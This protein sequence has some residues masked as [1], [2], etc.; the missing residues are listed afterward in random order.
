MIV[1]RT[2]LRINFAAGGSDLPAYYHQA[3]GAVIGM[4]IATYVYVCVKPN[5]DGR[6]LAH[7]RATEDVE[8]ASDLRHTRMRACLAHFGIK[9]G[10]EIASLADVPGSTGLGSSGAFLVGL[11]TALAAYTNERIAPVEAARL[12]WQ[13]E[14]SIE[15][16]G[17]QD[18]YFAALGGAMLLGFHAD[19]SVAIDH[20]AVR[21]DLVDHLLLLATPL[22][23]DAGAILAEQ[24][25]TFASTAPIV[26]QIVEMAYQFVP[27]LERGRYQDAGA[28]LD[29][30][31]Q[32]K[33]ML[34]PGITNDAIDGYYAAARA[35]GAW[36]GKV[37]GAGGG[38]FML[39]LASPDRHADIC[40]ALGLRVVPVRIA[41][42]GSRVVYG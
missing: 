9:R 37:C 16:V 32:L 29:E 11:I 22:T 23:R 1:T 24:A 28:L 36:G 18:Q 40:H 33:R 31:W 39:F 7:Y 2:P 4:T 26:A 30:V 10:I 15:A 20:V 5:F 34:A 21:G 13:I 41:P 12:A 35:A 42:Y 6:V 19:E 8:Q 17:K 27:L 38:G 14:T 25:T 3:P